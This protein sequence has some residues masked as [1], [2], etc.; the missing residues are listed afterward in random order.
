MFNKYDQAREVEDKI[1]ELIEEQKHKLI[2]PV[3]AFITFQEEDGKIVADSFEHQKGDKPLF[4]GAPLEFIEA[5]EPTNIIWE[6]RHHDDTHYFKE[7]IK[8]LI[9][10]GCL[11]AVSFMT[12]Y[13]FKSDAIAQSRIY[14]AI[15][16]ND[17]IRLYQTP[18]N[19]TAD[20][21]KMGL[22]YEHGNQEY[23]YLLQTQAKGEKPYLNGYYQTFCLAYDNTPERFED[24]KNK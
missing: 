8:V 6:N 7:G 19:N 1:F 23:K 3:D 9:L 4:L 10:V 12:I 16:G 21:S 11:L 22:L 24:L 5:T 18:A 17:V 20:N 2:R 15:K 14:P 13:F